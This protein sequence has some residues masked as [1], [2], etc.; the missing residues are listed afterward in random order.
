M[1]AET[2]W[3]HDACHAMREIYRAGGFGRVV[4][5]DTTTTSISRLTRSTMA[6]RLAPL[7]SHALT[8]YYIGVTGK[9]LRPCRARVSWRPAWLW[10]RQP[11]QD[12]RLATRSPSSRPAKG[13]RRGCRYCTSVYGLVE[14]TGR[15]F[16][17]RGWMEGLEYRGTLKELPDLAGQPCHRAWHRV[18]MVDRTD[19]FPTSLSRPSSRIAS[20][21]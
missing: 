20:R 4:Y 11:V 8:A 15:I 16:G 3:Y 7:V 21:R 14:E 12:F 13:A 5:S 2:S 6:D 19:S 9:R 17:E 18:G 10:S 1:M